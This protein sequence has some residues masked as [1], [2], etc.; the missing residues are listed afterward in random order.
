MES[1]FVEDV[2]EIR[3]R[4]RLHIERGAVTDGYTADRESV[5]ELLNH[6]LAT[7]IVCV[8]R[9]RHDSFMAV[10]I[11]GEPV[12][13]EFREHAAEE[14]A[15]ADRIAARVAQ[16]GG[17]PNFDPDGLKSR[18]HSEYVTA[19]SLLEMIRENLVAERIAID[20][21]MGMIRYIGDS[22]P[23]TRRLLEDILANEEEHAQELGDL[24]AALDPAEKHA[25]TST[26]LD[27]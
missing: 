25:G 10:G 9:Y 4:A 15:H 19:P 23:T 20:S 17:D 6:A 14:Q 21:Y 7:E 2:K 5:I 3:R 13:R 1:D 16:L 11:H 27:R 24:L 26:P 12:A 8:L 22:D 18:S